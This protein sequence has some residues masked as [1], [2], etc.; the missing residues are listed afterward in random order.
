M[1]VGT[2]LGEKAKSSITCAFRAQER[3]LGF[4]PC[5]RGRYFTHTWH[6]PVSIFKKFALATESGMAGVC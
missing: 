3:S 4:T 2:E 1:I 5:I 6:N